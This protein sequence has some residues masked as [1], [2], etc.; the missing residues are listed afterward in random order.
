M[1]TNKNRDAY[2]KM[3]GRVTACNIYEYAQIQY[4]L[5]KPMRACPFLG[6]MTILTISLSENVLKAQTEKFIYTATFRGEAFT[7]EYII[8]SISANKNHTFSLSKYF[9]VL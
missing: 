4:V 2:V 6:A 3:V 5:T 1:K 8:L 9:N 7:I